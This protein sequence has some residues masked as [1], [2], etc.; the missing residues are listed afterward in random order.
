MRA[1]RAK[2]EGLAGGGGTYRVASC[3]DV[4][5]VLDVVPVQ[6]A[7]AGA[8]AEERVRVVVDRLERLDVAHRAVHRAVHPVVGQH[9]HAF[10]LKT[11]SFSATHEGVGGGGGEGATNPTHRLKRAIAH[12]MPSWMDERVLPPEAMQYQYDA[13]AMTYHDSDHNATMA[14]SMYFPYFSLRSFRCC[15]TTFLQST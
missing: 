13:T 10:V 9:T 2:R 8:P 14:L 4:A 3:V 11:A 6:P 15:S 5:V 12:S 1:H 7:R